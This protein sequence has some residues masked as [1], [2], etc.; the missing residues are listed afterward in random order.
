VV[1][2]GISIYHHSIFGLRNGYQG[3]VDQQAV[4]LTLESVRGIL[5]QGGTIL[6][7]SRV[8]RSVSRTVP[9]GSERP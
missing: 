3:L 9:S 1:R 8:D 4:P 7:T 6:G 5:H 2:K